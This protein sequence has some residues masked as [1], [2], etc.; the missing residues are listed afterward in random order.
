MIHSL[1]SNPE[2]FLR[3]LISNASDAAD[4]LRF[5]ALDRPELHESDP[6]LAHPRRLRQGR[7]HHHGQ[8]QRH[9]HVARRG[10][11]ADRHHRQVRHARV[12]RLALRRPGQG[13]AADRPVRRRLLFLVHR[14]RSRDAHHPPRRTAGERRRALGIRGRGR[15]HDRADARDRSAAPRSCCTC[16]RTRTSSCRAGGCLD[17]PQVFRPHRAARS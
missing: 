16:A 12:L 2:I 5:E 1:Y 6:E 9:R 17:H 13:R 8:R 3:E 7:P 10:D 14:R 15:V 11:R 4:K